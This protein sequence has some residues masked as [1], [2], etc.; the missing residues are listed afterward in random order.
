METAAEISQLVAS[1]LWIGLAVYVYVI[2]NKG[3]RK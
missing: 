1:F 2:L 3:T